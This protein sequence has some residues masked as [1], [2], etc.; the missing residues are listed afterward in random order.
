MTSS[1]N[2]VRA[3][4]SITCNRSWPTAPAPTGRLLFTTRPKTS[5]R[6]STTSLKKPT[7]ALISDASPH[8]SM[9][10]TNSLPA[11]FDPA[12]ATGAAN[13]IHVCL[14]LQPNER[15]TLI[16]DQACAE[17]A[18]SLVA[19]IEKTGAAYQVLVLEEYGVRPH[20]D[21]PAP[22]LEDLAKSQVS[23]YACITQTGELR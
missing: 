4:R 15:M 13:A 9:P 10:H 16:T 20:R 17:I 14:K 5:N 18:A 19:E 22:V 3:T 8:G 6:S 7:T 1:T 2:S 12:L 21:M 23:I 11:T